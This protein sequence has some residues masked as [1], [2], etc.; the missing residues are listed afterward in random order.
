LRNQP[1]GSGGGVGRCLEVDSQQE[2][3]AE[4]AVSSIAAASPASVA[5]R[6]PG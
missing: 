4:V 2:N 6:I 1:G 3:Q 5:V